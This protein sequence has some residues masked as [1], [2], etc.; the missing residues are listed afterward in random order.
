MTVFQATDAPSTKPNWQIERLQ[1][2]EVRARVI[3]GLRSSGIRM[4]INV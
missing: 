2:A 4:L 3:R 1:Y